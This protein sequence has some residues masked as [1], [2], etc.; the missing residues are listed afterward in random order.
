MVIFL[1]YKDNRYSRAIK[2]AL[3]KRFENKL[4]VNKEIAK[5]ISEFPH[6]TLVTPG[7]Y[8]MTNNLHYFVVQRLLSQHWVSGFYCPSQLQYFS[9]LFYHIPNIFRRSITKRK[10]LFKPFGKQP[11]VKLRNLK[12][13][14]GKTKYEQV[15]NFSRILGE[16]H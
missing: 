14:L 2:Q 5:I 7:A 13:F 11:F 15:S 16:L 12:F 3:N 4:T 9:G 6:K 1:P 8:L 10:K